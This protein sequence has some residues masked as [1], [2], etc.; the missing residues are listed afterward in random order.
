MQLTCKDVHQAGIA[1]MSPSE[2]PVLQRV[3]FHNLKLVPR[4]RC[5]YWHTP[6]VEVTT[7]N[8][9]N[10]IVFSGTGLD[11]RQTVPRHDSSVSIQFRVLAFVESLV[12]REY[13]RQVQKP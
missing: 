12:C 3:Q 10:I 11:S 4:N 8:L 5:R 7:H 6:L 9:S 1:L 2:Q 13:V